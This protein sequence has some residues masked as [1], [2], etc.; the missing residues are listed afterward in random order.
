[1]IAEEK[2]ADEILCL[3]IDLDYEEKIDSAED[4]FEPEEKSLSE[5]I[6]KIVDKIREPD[7]AQFY[8][9]Y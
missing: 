1:M 4:F 2:S 9:N 3:E 7:A 6:K 8:F 5:S